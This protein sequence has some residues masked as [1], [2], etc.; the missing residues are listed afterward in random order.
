MTRGRVADPPMGM[1]LCYQYIQ[2][3]RVDDGSG[4][5]SRWVCLTTN[6]DVLGEIAWNG[7]WRQYVLTTRDTI[8]SA[9][10]LADVQHFIGQL[11]EARRRSRLANG[12]V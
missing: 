10:C 4:K 5:T 9:G 7:R 3:R 12:K 2:F 8:W 6:N 1:K 11:V